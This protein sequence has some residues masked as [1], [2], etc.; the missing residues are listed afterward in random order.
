MISWL[1]LMSSG[2]ARDGPEAA[3]AASGT[4]TP[5][6]CAMAGA[7]RSA[8]AMMAVRMVSDPLRQF[9]GDPAAGPDRRIDDRIA[10]RLLGAGG[11]RGVSM[12][13]LVGLEAGDIPGQSRVAVTQLLQL[14][15]IMSVDLV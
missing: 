1:T 6:C 8:K 5:G 12:L 3:C 4:G 2:P 7:P 13:A 11:E 10:D 15:G 9:D 14:L